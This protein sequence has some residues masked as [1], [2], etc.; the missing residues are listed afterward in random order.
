MKQKIQFILICVL[1]IS[2]LLVS[3]CS[4][5]N[6]TG[7]QSLTNNEGEKGTADDS[8]GD[9]VAKTKITFLAAPPGDVVNLKDNEFT[10]YV[11]EQFGLQINWNI[12]TGADMVTKQ[13]IMLASGDYPEV[14]WNGNFSPSDILKYSKQGLVVPLN[15]Y[16]DKYAPN[17]KEALETAPGLKEITVAP[18]GKIYG[19]PNY[20]WCYHCYW[21]SKLWINTKYLDEVGLQMPTTTEELEVVLQAFKD[22]GYV[23]LAGAID[24]NYPDPTT[25]LMNAFV[26]ND[27]ATYFNVNEG[28]L[29]FV[30]VLD[31]W[32][33]GLTYIHGLYEKGLIDKQAYSQKWDDLRRQ[34]E[35]QKVATF[36]TG[37]SFFILPNGPQN[38]DYKYW[39]TV[40][41][42]KGPNGAQFAA[43]YGNGPGGLTFVVTN[44]ATEEQKIALA[45]LLNF[46]YSPEGTQMLDFGKEGKH[47]TKAEAGMVGLN[48][49]DALFKTDFSAFYAAGAKQNDGWNQMGPIFQSDRWRNGQAAASADTPEGTETMLHLETLK[50]YTGKQPAQVYPGAIWISEVE[51]QKYSMLRTNINKY[52]N[53]W[54]AQF[55][56]GHKSIEQS[57]D[58]YVDGLG[59]LGLD[60][61]IKLSEKYMGKPF[62]TSAFAPEPEAVKALEALK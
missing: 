51:N 41:P 19:M 13:N 6:N 21:M 2:I 35:Q 57:W 25:Y 5:T 18:D 30:P 24:G 4:Q 50:N 17:V 20:N 60:E 32:K 33:A 12:T 29:S 15:D 53:E 34:V 10:K 61:Y 42:L 23:P 22:K 49:Q 58:D 52:V 14:I 54:M 3:A 40:P 39:K 48:G 56:V 47:W 62:D 44:K 26:Y 45:K 1:S 38:P 59:K 8:K 9:T 37:G 55:I 28:K 46:I 16:I 27:R 11:E 43:F 31:D 7:K 36:S